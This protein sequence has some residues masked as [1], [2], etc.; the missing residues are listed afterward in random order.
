VIGRSKLRRNYTVA[1]DVTPHSGLLASLAAAAA[2]V[3]WTM[4]ISALSGLAAAA[5]ESVLVN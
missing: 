3:G 2:V 1:L 5:G 4:A